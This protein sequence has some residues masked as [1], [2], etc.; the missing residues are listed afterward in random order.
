MLVIVKVIKIM[1]HLKRVMLNSLVWKFD[2]KECS[3]E[4]L[5]LQA[6]K[7]TINE[8]KTKLKTGI[9]NSFTTPLEAFQVI[10]GFDY[11]FVKHL[12]RNSNDFI[13]RVI[14]PT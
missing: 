11:K 12:C 2:V 7:C 14:L 6:H 13:R 4:S 8:E 3:D 5:L 1:L 10:G 9:S